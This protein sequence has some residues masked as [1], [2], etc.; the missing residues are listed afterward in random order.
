MLVLDLQASLD[1]V[2]TSSKGETLLGIV[3]H[4]RLI[5]LV[6]FVTLAFATPIMMVMKFTFIERRREA[7][8][9]VETLRLGKLMVV[10]RYI[11]P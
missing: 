1:H 9:T 7:V 6:S 2:V 4:V 11:D 8:A 10:V 5:P 3:E